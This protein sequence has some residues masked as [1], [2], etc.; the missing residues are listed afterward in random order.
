MSTTLATKPPEDWKGSDLRSRS[1]VVEYLRAHGGEITD[2]TGLVV[3]TM[4]S[5]LGKGRA[6][7][8]LL[9]DME[10]DGMI[11]REVR[12]RRTFRITL[13]E[14]WGLA[15]PGPVYVSPL[16]GADKPAAE[17]VLDENVDYDSLATTLLA[18]VVK[19][20]SAPAEQDARAQA[21]IAEL[22]RELEQVQEECAVL[23][24]TND[25]LDRN[26]HVFQAELDKRP[27]RGSSTL[28]D[29]LSDEEQSTLDQLMRSLPSNR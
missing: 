12:G 4:R 24:T 15:N 6:L 16:R 11:E 7:S 8:Q 25:L 21:R 26:L 17:P 29:R 28:R 3:G 20:I 13:K 19:R 18:V 1:E 5:E 22:Q 9:A 14:D 27:K 10:S 2:Q 23:R